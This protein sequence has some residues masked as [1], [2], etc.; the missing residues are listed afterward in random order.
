MPKAVRM[1][2]TVTWPMTAIATIASSTATSTVATAFT[3]S[4]AVT[5]T[6]KG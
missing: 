4:I 2:R 5:N 6:R 1:K 3:R